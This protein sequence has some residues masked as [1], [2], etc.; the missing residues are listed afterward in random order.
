MSV[1]LEGHD[2]LIF[3]LNSLQS[4]SVSLKRLVI[5]FEAFAKTFRSLSTLNAHLKNASSLQEIQQNYSVFNTKYESSSWVRRIVCLQCCYIPQRWHSRYPLCKATQPWTCVWKYA[6]TVHTWQ[7]L[8][9]WNI[10]MGTTAEKSLQCFEKLSTQKL[11]ELSM[12][13]RICFLRDQFYFYN[14]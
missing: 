1:L 3:S 2:F 5:P 13:K 10:S 9:P 12:I 8:F 4:K 7:H 6:T 11:W 14:K